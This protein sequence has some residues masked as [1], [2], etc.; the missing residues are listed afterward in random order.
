MPLIRVNFMALIKRFLKTNLKWF[1]SA[2]I[3]ASGGRLFTMVIP[4]FR[5][6]TLNRFSL[7]LITSEALKY[8]G[9][10]VIPFI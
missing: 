9:F 4:L 5:I 1:K 8:V 10:K 6:D 2:C 7:L 3:V